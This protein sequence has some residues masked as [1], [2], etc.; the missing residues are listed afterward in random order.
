[1]SCVY[2]C[3]VCPS[4]DFAC[5]C[6][7]VCACVCVCTAGGGGVKAGRGPSGRRD[8]E[9]ESFFDARKR[10]LAASAAETAA[11]L[12]K[13]RGGQGGRVCCGGLLG[14]FFTRLAD[15]CVS[16]S[17][18]ASCQCCPLA[19]LALQ[20]GRHV[21]CFVVLADTWLC[22]TDPACCAL[23]L[24][25]LPIS[26][27]VCLLLCVCLWP[28]SSPFLQLDPA[29]RVALAG[30]PVGSYVRLRISGECVLVCVWGGGV[31]VCM[32]VEGW[33]GIWVLWACSSCPA[34][35]A[36]PQSAA[37]KPSKLHA[38]PPHCSCPH[39]TSASAVVVPPAPKQTGVPYELVSHWDPTRPLLLGGLAP[40]EARMGVMRLR[41]KRHR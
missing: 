27:F 21:R 39:S 32:Y 2:C 23:T 22:C 5:V 41:V 40:G 26:A 31:G 10:E 35:P 36:S 12:A 33:G 28:V 7:L 29:T 3:V 37:H 15:C 18:I 20:A 8:E 17:C 25:R 19:T 1:M 6:V 9:G 24:L 4:P 16:L 14:S 34:L 38:A 11:A 30:H 13:A